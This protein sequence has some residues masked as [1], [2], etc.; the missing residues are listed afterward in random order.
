LPNCLGRKNAT[1]SHGCLVITQRIKC[2]ISNH[3][4]LSK[5]WVYL[6]SLESVGKRIPRIN[7]HQLLLEEPRPN[8]VSNRGRW[9]CRDQEKWLIGVFGQALPHFEN[10]VALKDGPHLMAYEQLIPS[11]PTALTMHTDSLSRLWFGPDRLDL[12]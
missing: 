8:I 11:L 5:S 6:P 9:Q 7:G 12:R 2:R 4:G 1:C 10:G 3:S